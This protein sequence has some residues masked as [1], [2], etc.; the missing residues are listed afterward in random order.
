MTVADLRER[1]S[2]DEFMRWYVHFGRK[3]QA[4]EMVA[5][6]QGKR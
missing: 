6:L 1:M 3:A 2:G 5:A 4:Q